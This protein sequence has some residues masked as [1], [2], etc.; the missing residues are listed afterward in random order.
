MQSDSYDIKRFLLIDDHTMI[1]SAL[2]AQCLEM[3]PGSVVEESADGY[4]VMELLGAGSFDLVIVDMQIRNCDTLFLISS[5]S[6]NYAKVPVL[7]YSMTAENIYALKVMRAGAK[8]F[9]SKEASIQELERAIRLVIQGKRYISDEVAGI[10]SDTSFKLVVNPFSAL[11]S[12]QLQIAALLLAG[13]TVTE[14]SKQLHLGISTVG[15][16][17]GKIFHKLGVLNL[18][19]LKL[20]SDVYRF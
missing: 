10:V 5:I 20:I 11:S 12:R 14:I 1:R 3:Y 16:H 15:T 7:V 8:G 18:L 19:E 4:G 13:Q 2:K 9:I 6:L 17:K